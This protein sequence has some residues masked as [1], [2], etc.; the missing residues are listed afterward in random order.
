M[1]TMAEPMMESQPPVGTVEVDGC[2]AGPA[3]EAGEWPA[4]AGSSY[5]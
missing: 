1:M 3:V 5:Q 2:Q 4:A